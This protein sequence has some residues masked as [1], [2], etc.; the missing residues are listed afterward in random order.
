MEYF[1]VNTDNTNLLLNKIFNVLFM[2]SLYV[3][4]ILTLLFIADINYE[5][6][7]AALVGSISGAAVLGYFR[8]DNTFWEK[9]IKLI[10]SSISGGIIGAA[11]NRYYEIT[12]F[13]YLITIF[14]I[15]SFSSL[16][17]LRAVLI[18]TEKN[19]GT[20][21][22]ITFMRVFGLQPIPQKKEKSHKNKRLQDK[23]ILENKEIENNNISDN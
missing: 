4:N 8:R 20:I 6:L 9:I 1:L 7:I 15:S 10:C 5:Y 16:I 18:L 19:A 3:A 12:Y 22:S 13:E 23:T 11:I 17:I 2:L 14:F 21:I